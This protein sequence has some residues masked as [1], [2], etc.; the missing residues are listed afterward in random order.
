MVFKGDKTLFQSLE[1]SNITGIS[2]DIFTIIVGVCMR[3][4][5]GRKGIMES[6]IIVTAVNWVR[7][8]GLGL[9]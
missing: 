8:I 7:S 6:G 2:G 3:K 1:I 4:S 9:V 5:A